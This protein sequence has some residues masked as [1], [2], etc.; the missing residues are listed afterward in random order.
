[1]YL[2]IEKSKLFLQFVKNANYSKDEKVLIYHIID[3][4]KKHVQTKT[5]LQ[6]KKLRNKLKDILCK[7]SLYSFD[8]SIFVDNKKRIAKGSYGEIYDSGIFEGIPVITKTPIFFD[9]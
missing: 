5:C 9:T 1:M 7:F 4:L 3:F 6:G 8:H 2:P